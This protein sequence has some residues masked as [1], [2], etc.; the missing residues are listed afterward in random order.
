MLEANA[1]SSASP[2][3]SVALLHFAGRLTPMARHECDAVR[4]QPAARRNE[5]I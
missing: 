1:R 3:R 2:N 5:A 4:L